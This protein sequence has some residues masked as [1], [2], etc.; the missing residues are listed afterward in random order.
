MNSLFIYS[1]FNDAMSTSNYGASNGKMISKYLIWKDVEG[2]GQWPSL[3][4][5][6]AFA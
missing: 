1:I 3:K 4:Y 2:S 5:F 6:F